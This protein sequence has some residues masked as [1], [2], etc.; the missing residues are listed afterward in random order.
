MLIASRS[1]NLVTLAYEKA[2]SVLGK[3]KSYFKIVIIFRCQQCS[4]A[5]AAACGLY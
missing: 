3:L 2:E 4:S 5:E 1:I